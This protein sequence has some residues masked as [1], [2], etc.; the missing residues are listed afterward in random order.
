MASLKVVELS[1][2]ETSSVLPKTIE[3]GSSIAESVL[4]KEYLSIRDAKKQLGVGYEVYTRRL[5]LE[6]KLEGVKVDHGHYVKWHISRDSIASYMVN[7][8]RTSQAR[9]YILRMEKE[10]EA[11]V[12]EALDKAGIEY[13]LEL[14]YKGKG[15]KNDK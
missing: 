5:L 9:R 15:D 6:Q 4:S 8:R 11:A 3:V 14:S 12:R 7:N 13:E 10:H 1:R 2:K